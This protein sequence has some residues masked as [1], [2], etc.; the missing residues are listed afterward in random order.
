MIM[1]IANPQTRMSYTPIER[2]LIRDCTL[3]CDIEKS[4]A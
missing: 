4:V 3:D 1:S 2:D